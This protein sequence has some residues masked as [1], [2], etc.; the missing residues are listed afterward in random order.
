MKSRDSKGR[1]TKGNTGGGRK[2]MPKAM[3]EMAQEYAPRAMQFAF[4][5]MENENEKTAYRLEAAKLIIERAYGKP[6]QEVN[7]ALN[8][9]GG[10]FVLELVGDPDE[11]A[12]AD[13]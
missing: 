1:F 6:T 3:K 9:S 7:A 12:Q 5:V 13:S 2:P 10:D 8:Y 11:E 4:E